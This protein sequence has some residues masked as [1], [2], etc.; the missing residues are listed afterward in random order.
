MIS[1]QLLQI[2]GRI[3]E[4][5]FLGNISKLVSGDILAQLAAFAA[6]PFI[7]RIYGPEAFGLLGIFM[8]FSDVGAKFANLRYDIALVLPESDASAWALYRLAQRWALC[9]VLL[10]LLFSYNYR[11]EITGYFDVEVIAPYFPLIALMVLAIG[12]QGLASYWSMRMLHFKALAEA[13]AGSALIGSAFKILA[14]VS[15]MGPAGLLLGTAV[16]RWLNFLFIRVRTPG[17]IWL[18]ATSPGNAKRQ[19]LQYREFPL[20]RMPQDVLN[21]CSRM[22]P[23]VLMLA[24]FGPLAAGFYILADRIVQLPFS[25]FQEAVRKVFYVKAVEAERQG[26]ELLQLSLKLTGMLLFVIVPALALVIFCGPLA[27]SIIFG[28]AWIVSGEYA[29]WI[30]V[31]VLANFI[32]LPASVLIPVMK[33]NRFYLIFEALSSV[34][35]LS[36]IALVGCNFT[37]QTTVMSIALCSAAVSLL[38]FSIVMFRLVKTGRQN[39]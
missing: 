6:L 36:I 11:W 31:A 10:V 32:C 19:L 37:A 21:C 2:S 34:F 9:F 39:R 33:W 22:L 18:H 28:Q 5:A 12:W 25:L 3:R 16:Q 1:S 4:S 8:A 29:R 35:R 15:G 17:S 20:Y 7:T 27:F 26:G 13:S 30:M 38:L 24:F 14:G 23:N